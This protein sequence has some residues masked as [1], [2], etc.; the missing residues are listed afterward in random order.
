[1]EW[2]VY[3]NE[4]V[5]KKDVRISPFIDGVM[6]GKGFFETI[7]VKNGLPEYL[8]LHV[9][10]IKRACN[11]FNIKV[12][13]KHVEKNILA[14]IKKCKAFSG[15]YK[16]KI[17]VLDGENIFITLDEYETFLD[18]DF[19][20]GIIVKTFS[21]ASYSPYAGFKSTSYF[22]YKYLLSESKKSGANTALLVDD[23]GRI[24]EC[25]NGNILYFD[26]AT[27]FVPKNN[28][29]RLQGIKELVVKDIL[30]KNSITVE[31]RDIYLD[32]I[33]DGNLFF[34]N[35]MIDPISIKT[36]LYKE[37]KIVLDVKNFSCY[38]CS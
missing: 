37:Y 24:L 9:G 1:M 23:K 3:N 5:K 25:C 6:F 12:S 28:G 31:N 15:I 13:F 27:W 29:E 4:V 22:Y 10:R 8:D 30:L 11:Y 17:I 34:L 19:K 2:V 7:C 14:L 35:S 32:E 26:G 20:N 33:K 16:G 38:K 36:I 18:E 21:P